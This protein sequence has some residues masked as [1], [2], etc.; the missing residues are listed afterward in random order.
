MQCARKEYNIIVVLHLKI[1]LVTPSPLH[2]EWSNI[3]ISH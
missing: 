1:N 3:V 2:I